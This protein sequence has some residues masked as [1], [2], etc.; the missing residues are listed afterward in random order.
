MFPS[1]GLQVTIFNESFL[2]R[3]NKLSVGKNTVKNFR[4]VGTIG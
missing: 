3:R 1:D 2:F 4:A